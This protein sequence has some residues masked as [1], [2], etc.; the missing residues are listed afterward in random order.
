MQAIARSRHLAAGDRHGARPRRV[1]ERLSRPGGRRRVHV[2][3]A[4]GDRRAGPQGITTRT[5][6]ST[7]AWTDVRDRASGRRR[8]RG[9]DRDRGAA[10]SPRPATQVDATGGRRGTAPGRQRHRRGAAR[11][12]RAHRAR[13]RG[14]GGERPGVLGSRW[15]SPG[16]STSS[17]TSPGC[18]S[19]SWSS[20]PELLT[21]ERRPARRRAH[22]WHRRVVDGCPGLRGDLPA[23][24]VR[25]RPP[26]RWASGVERGGQRRP[27]RHLGQRATRHPGP[28][29]RLLVQRQEAQRHLADRLQ[30][31]GR[32]LVA[33]PAETAA[34]PV[35]HQPHRGGRAPARAGRCGP[36][37]AGSGRAGRRCRRR[38]TRSASSST[39]A[40][41]PL[42]AGRGGVEGQLLVLLE[43]EPAV[44]DD[45][46]RR[47]AG[48]R[49]AARAP[50]AG[51]SAVHR[52]AR[53]RP[54]STRSDGATTP[55]GAGQR[56]P[57]RAPRRRRPGP[58]PARPR[59]RRAPRASARSRR[60]TRRRRRAA[61]GM[62]RPAAAAATPSATVDRPGAP[63]GP[64]T[65]TTPAA[66]GSGSRRRRA[67][68]VG[69]C[70][71]D[72]VSG[73]P[74]PRTFGGE[75]D[76]LS[77]SACGS[78]ATSPAPARRHRGAGTARRPLLLDHHQRP[79]PRLRP[80][81]PPRRRPSPAQAARHH[82]QPGPAGGGR[83]QQVGDVDASAGQASRGRRAWSA[84]AAARLPAGSSGGDEYARGKGCRPSS[85][86]AAATQ[87]PT[88]T[89]T[90]DP[91]ASV[92][93]HVFE[94]AADLAAGDR[95]VVE[96]DHHLLGSVAQRRRRHAR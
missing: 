52:S 37:P 22:S 20:A 45:Q 42:R 64:H 25:A 82:G 77:T 49:P 38:R 72:R 80:A 34:H 44:D 70:P 87:P 15:S 74:C 14:A 88:R 94:V 53:G 57:R 55:G 56:W 31:G 85:S 71:V 30:Q 61:L 65:A 4:H 3:V 86:P 79:R 62:P 18:W 51:R 75:G 43:A 58:P 66:A 68:R 13:V 24:P 6:G 81:E 26:R 83:G 10:R 28:V 41:A 27:R 7:T 1:R 78:A 2:L 21:S 11:A 92:P 91:G 32:D 46:R 96:T 17:C 67:H 16:S 93:E 48:R 40:V 19:P 59:P 50:P 89:S 35:D 54:V 95:A 23:P 29:D 90:D 60:R 5:T 63:V 84:A 39:V 12:H 8:R 9:R 47:R 76:E 33:R 69:R 73:R 36:G